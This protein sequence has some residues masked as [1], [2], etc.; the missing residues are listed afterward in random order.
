MAEFKFPDEQE[1]ADDPK[2]V[3]ESKETFEI[4]IKDD[5][6]TKDR[7]RKVSEAPADVTDEELG[8]YSDKV[9]KRIQHFN[10]G[11]HD[12]RRAKETALREKQ[13]LEQVAQ[14]L[15]KEIGSLKGTVAKNQEA[16]LEQ[17]KMAATEELAQAE[18]VYKTA[19][20]SGDADAVV[21]STKKMTEATLK[22]ERINN[23]TLPPLQEETY[24]V[25]PRTSAPAVDV[26]DKAVAWQQANRWFG[27]DDEMTS[28]A[29]GLH[30]KLVKQGIDPTSNEYYEKIN[31]RMQQVF[32]DQIE[33]QEQADKPR[34]KTN[35]VAPATRSTAPRKIVLTQTQVNIAKRLGVPIELY[36]KQVA[37]DLRKQNG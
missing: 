29:L 36:A 23:F 30:Q 21:S 5:T 27:S 22:A 8:A 6:P 18:R 11:Y 10:K 1:V 4:E 26:D 17:A 37:A 25:K 3:N 20:E 33:E 28:F 14:R 9:R 19:Y 13:E 32:P 24:E 31:S 15:V 16:I 2:S 34:R 12:E 35:V 7:D